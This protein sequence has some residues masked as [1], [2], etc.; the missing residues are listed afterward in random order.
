MVALAGVSH[1]GSL[2]GL[3]N[4]PLRSMTL[5]RRLP[6]QSP[7]GTLPPGSSRRRLPVGVLASYS[8][9]AVWPCSRRLVRAWRH[10]GWAQTAGRAVRLT[11]AILAFAAFLGSALWLVPYF[12]WIEQRRA[13]EARLS[14][15]RAQALSASSTLACLEGAGDTIEKACE[16][17]VFATP[18]SLA[19]ANFYMT[20]RFDVLT[21]AARY[22][23]PRTPQFDE[24]ITALQ[25]SLE[26]DPFGLTA[27]TLALRT[28]CT[29]E[30][31]DAIAMFG[32]KARVRENVRQKTYQGIVARHSANW[33]TSA[34][35][36]AFPLCALRRWPRTRAPIPDKYT[37]PSASSIPPIS[38]MQDEPTERRPSAPATAQ[39]RPNAP[40]Q[41]GAVKSLR[42]SSPT[43]RH[44]LRRH[45]LQV[46]R[47]LSAEAAS[48][49]SRKKTAERAARNHSSTKISAWS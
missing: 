10:C 11:L 12:G 7:A 5:C 33:R 43:R 34:P 19:A 13:I 28:G 44:L 47:P 2:V 21:S 1:N 38:I 29:A 39:D 27:N 8:T 18:E 32:E 23:G 25:R 40:V 46:R 22:S 20:T 36:V 4:W 14:E 9:F 49:T 15:L 3:S 48:G 6:K 17:T 16:Q 42:R 24:A 45:F 26:Q 41:P 30:R 35:T 31:C 37:L